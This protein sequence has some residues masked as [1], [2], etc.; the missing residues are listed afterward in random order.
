MLPEVPTHRIEFIGNAAAV[1]ARMALLCRA[2]R[3]E[4]AEISENSEYV[5]LANRPDFQ[6]LFTEGMMFPEG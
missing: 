5:E 1:G 4:A 3:A 6:R 2:C